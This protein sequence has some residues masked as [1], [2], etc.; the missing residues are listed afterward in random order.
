MLYAAD[1]AAFLAINH[2]QNGPWLDRFFLTATDFGTAWLALGACVVMLAATHRQAALRPLFWGAVLIAPLALVDLGLKRLIARPRPPLELGD[3]ARVVGPRLEMYSFPSGH[4][5]TAAAVLGFLW[6]VD[7]RLA[8]IWLPCTL[9]VCLS[10]P[11]LGVHF[12][13]DVVA[14][15]VL[16][17]AITYASARALDLG[18]KR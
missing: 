1:K 7:R 17:F 9:L 3:L 12:P 15:A 10:R 6:V 8:W 13:S 18:I 2:W 11:Y 4:A 14:G 16:G 5:F